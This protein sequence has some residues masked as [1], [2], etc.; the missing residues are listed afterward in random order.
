MLGRIHDPTSVEKAM[1]VAAG[2]IEDS[3]DIVDE[4]AERFLLADAELDRAFSQAY[5]DYSG[6]QAEKRH[7]A[8][9]AT[10]ELRRARDIAYLN[11]RYA[12]RKA[13]AIERRLS[14]LQSINK[15]VQ[16]AYSVG[17]GSR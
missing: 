17:G 11:H 4:L 14:S 1:D 7:A 13:N 6:P 12:E 2:R 15:G 8:E 3:V 5:L 10:A 16:T 9:V